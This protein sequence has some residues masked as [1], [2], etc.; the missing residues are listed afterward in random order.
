MMRVFE[1]QKIRHFANTEAFHEERFRLVDDE[2]M[3]IADGR[4]A[5]GMMNHITEVS[6]RISQFRCAPGNAGK[7]LFVLQAFG[8]IIYQ[9]AVEAFEDVT[10]A[11]FL[12]GEL[13]KVDSLAVGQNQL[14]VAFKDTL[15]CR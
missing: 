7:A 6:G 14:Q 8:E 1:A 4:A 11:A 13:P 2:I 15:K 3:D 5:G 10:F 12:L 9:Q